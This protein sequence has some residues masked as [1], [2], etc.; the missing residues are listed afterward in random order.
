MNTVT[1]RGL[2]VDLEGYDLTTEKGR[3]A[4][5]EV[6]HKMEHIQKEAEGAVKALKALG[7]EYM[8]ST[9]QVKRSV[10]NWTFKVQ[11]SDFMQVNANATKALCKEKDID[12]KLC[13]APQH[14]HFFQLCK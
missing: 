7:L 9:Q 5:A 6:L 14:R 1:I 4:F 12:Y 10:G 2:T 3:I 13:C 11:T 8:D